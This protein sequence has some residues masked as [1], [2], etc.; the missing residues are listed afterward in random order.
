MAWVLLHVPNSVFS[1]TMEA[2]DIEEEDAAND[3]DSTD[4]VGD[5]Q[6]LTKVGMSEEERS[7]GAY[8]EREINDGERKALNRLI[9]TK[10]SE[11]A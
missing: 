11:K 7:N 5:M 10:D 1:G 4:T 2:M 9:E 6:S 8:G 3:E